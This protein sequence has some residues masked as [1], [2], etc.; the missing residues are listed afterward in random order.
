MCRN[1]IRVYV[2]RMS[3]IVGPLILLK[4][5]PKVNHIKAKRVINVKVQF[6]YIL[7]NDNIY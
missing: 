6:N 4:F 3:V 5:M 1:I 2:K 7:L